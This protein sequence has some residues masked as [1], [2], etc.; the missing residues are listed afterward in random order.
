MKPKRSTKSTQI[1]VLL[2]ERLGFTLAA[3]LMGVFYMV[4]VI[5]AAWIWLRASP[6]SM[7]LRIDGDA[8][9]QDQTPKDSEE[10]EKAFSGSSLS[11]GV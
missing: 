7:G 2:V 1:C 9:E 11:F 10:P 5:P 4:G 6:E 8:A 3:P